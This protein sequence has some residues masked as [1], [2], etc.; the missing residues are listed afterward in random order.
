MVQGRQSMALK[1]EE[2]TKMNPLALHLYFL[3]KDTV[4]IPALGRILLLRYRA[5]KHRQ[6]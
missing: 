3:F 4:I 6:T 5:D 1:T 2:H